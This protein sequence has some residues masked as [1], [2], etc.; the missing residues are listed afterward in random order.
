MEKHRSPTPP[1]VCASI[2]FETQLL[3]AQSFASLANMIT[4]TQPWWLLPYCGRNTCRVAANEGSNQSPTVRFKIVC[5]KFFVLNLRSWN[6]TEWYLS[7]KVDMNWSKKHDK[8]TVGRSPISRHKVAKL[9]FSSP[10]RSWV[11]R[12]ITAKF[13]VF[14][15]FRCNP[16][17]TSLR[18]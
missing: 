15:F 16:E 11:E 4:N 6:F 3:V 8:R 7:L 14:E 9:S 10:D 12:R 13:L 2:G 18:E 5:K 17:R 1:L